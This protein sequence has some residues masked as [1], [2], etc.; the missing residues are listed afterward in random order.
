M[1]IEI[2]RAMLGWAAIINISLS[3]CWF[4][5]FS[6]ARDRIFRLHGQWFAI[7]KEHF[8]AL[9]YAGMMLLKLGTIMFF[10]APYLALGV[11]G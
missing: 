6:F 9:H 11:V 7:P 3:L 5:L 10:V 8:G 1:T 4:L 2:F